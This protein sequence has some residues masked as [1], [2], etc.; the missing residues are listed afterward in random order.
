MDYNISFYQDTRFKRTDNSYTIKLRIYSHLTQKSRLY[1]TKAALTEEDF[2]RFM[3]NKTLKGEKKEIKLRLHA[4]EVRA[5]EVARELDP[6]TLEKFD[7][8]MFTDKN[9][10]INV[11]QHYKNKIEALRKNE[12]LS[13]ASN[14]DLSLKSL[15]RFIEVKFNSEP[16]KLTFYDITSNWLE[17]YESFMINQ[18]GKSRT[19]VSMYLRALRT[20]FND[21]INENDIKRDIYPFGKGKGLYQIPSTKNKKKA[22]SQQQLAVLFSA[23]PKTQEQE[24]AKDF[25]YFSYAC[26]GMNLKDILLL[27]WDNLKEDSINYYRAKTVNTKKGNLTEISIFLNDYAMGIIDKY[28]NKARDRDN[29]IFPILEKGDGPEERYRKTKNF[30]SFVNLHF[31][32]LAK[33]QG[34]GFKVSSYWARHSFVTN[35]IRKGASM[36]FVS[37]ALNHSS[38]NVTKGY[39]AGFQD[40]V[41]K[42]FA[43]DIMNFE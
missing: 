24:M 37:D 39:F 23:V 16:E 17:L 19:T 6:F 3:H 11:F 32:K 1:S 9:A 2:E 4:L 27:K 28:G 33:T 42:E 38:L 5:N 26:N 29:Y 20:V 14:Y 40:D 7:R 34:F 13:T 36:E 41:K 10:S 43:K 31:N 21:A 25:W 30:T 15:N 18:L 22:L 8:K 35:A 12:Q